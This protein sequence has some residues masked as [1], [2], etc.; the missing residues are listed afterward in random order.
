MLRITTSSFVTLYSRQESPLLKASGIWRTAAVEGEVQ[1]RTWY[2]CVRKSKMNID[3][4]RLTQLRLSQSTDDEPCRDGGC[5]FEDPVQRSK[6]MSIME[7][8]YLL[9]TVALKRLGWC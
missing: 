3:R 4:G 5:L 7:V 9:V 1:V 8:R 6:Q 2:K